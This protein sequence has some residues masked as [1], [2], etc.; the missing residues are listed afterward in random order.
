MKRWFLAL[1]TV[2][3]LMCAPALMA[4]GARSSVSHARSSRSTKS[5]RANGPKVS[6]KSKVPGSHDGMYVGGKGSSHK[7]GNYKNPKTGNK[8][9]DRKAG[10]PK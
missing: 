4:K 1:T 5:K 7:G 3:A 8:E 9:R 2:L 10:V 6:K